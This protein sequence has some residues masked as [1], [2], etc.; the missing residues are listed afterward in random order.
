MNN[1]IMSFDVYNK[2]RF[3]RPWACQMGPTGEYDFE[4]RIGTYTGAEPGDAGDLIIFEPQEGQVY[5][6]GQKDY[7]GGKTVIRHALWNGEEF[8]PCDKLGRIK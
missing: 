2:R 6:Y 1:V 8:V 3:S 5:G 7:R 4:N